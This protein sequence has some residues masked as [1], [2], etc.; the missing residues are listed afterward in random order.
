MNNIL[1]G[2][3][4]AI[5]LILTVATQFA[6]GASVQDVGTY[7]PGSKK[8]LT[9]PQSVWG[10]GNRVGGVT[11][12]RSDLVEVWDWN[13]T[14]ATLK[15]LKGV[16]GK[17]IK[18]AITVDYY[19]AS[20]NYKRE[21]Y[22]Y[23]LTI[24]TNPIQMT[25]SSVS[26]RAGET[27]QLAYRGTVVGK[28]VPEVTWSSS[29]SSIATVGFTGIV[30]AK[31][32]G[33]AIITATSTDGEVTQCTV[34]VSGNSESG[35][36]TSGGMTAEVVDLGLSVKWTTCNLG[37]TTSTGVGYKY[38]WGATRPS[39]EASPGA[40]WCYEYTLEEKGVIKDGH[41]TSE[42]DACTQALGA[43]YRVPTKEEWEELS[44][45]CTWESVTI[46]GVSC[47]RGQS[48]RNGRIIIFPKTETDMP[49]TSLE[50]KRFMCWS[51]TH[52]FYG[53]PWAYYFIDSKSCPV[54][55]YDSV[56]RC[57]PLRA[58]YDTSTGIDDIPV[59]EDASYE[60][61]DLSG[62]KVSNDM[63]NLLPGIYIK[64]QGGK[65]QKILIH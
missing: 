15:I 4:F 26:M 3:A 16:A 54:D 65:S 28:P 59:T 23:S 17:S 40:T 57:Y 29:K 58:V 45:N 9:F 19:D 33:S 6:Y 27:H 12:S 1:R 60:L 36:S 41:F 55:L 18:V 20:K 11:S 22:V 35:G 7:Y 53:R 14:G 21:S 51:S 64:V 52:Y 25:E 44:N 49:G 34:N 48:K 50:Q 8:I 43:G 2:M 32:E 47:I 61:F 31:S 46:D 42:Y 37:A 24:K 13:T 56:K 10:N 39:E 63:N 62:L 5:A 38:A 30:T